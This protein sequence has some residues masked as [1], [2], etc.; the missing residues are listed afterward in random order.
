MSTPAAQA[1]VPSQIT[2]IRAFNRFYT[3]RLGLLRKRH[4]NGDFSLTEARTLYEIGANPGLTARTLRN[5]LE[6][7]AGYISRTLAA[8]QKRCLIRQTTS[9]QDAREKHLS[10]TATG[11][12]VV[13]K[14]NQQSEAQIQQILAMI[15][16]A[17]RSELA[18]A[19]TRVH[20]ILSH[21]S[22][23]KINILRLTKPT[24][25]ALALIHEYYEAV[26]VVQRDTPEKLAKI[27]HAPNSAMWLAYLDNKAVGCVLLRDLPI[28]NAAECKRLYVQP[29]ARGHHIA[30]RLM[31]ALEDD[32]RSLGLTDLYLDSYHDLEAAIA[33][34]RNR[35]YEECPRYNDNPQATIFLRKQL[36]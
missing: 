15:P 19:L 8:L 24:P 25:E 1:P 22:E 31:D 3:A 2:A 30:A 11:E 7:D 29:T 10:L 4:L 21:S 5:T 20:R 32:A 9:K 34:Y 36:A 13:A 26:H 12:K 18:A 6:L 14:L 28:P 17:E 33:L 16:T 27:L 35:G 23:N